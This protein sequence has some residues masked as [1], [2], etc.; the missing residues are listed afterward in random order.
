MQRGPLR[1]VTCVDIGAGLDQELCHHFIG[2]E[3]AHSLSGSLTRSVQE[4]IAK[5]KKTG[6]ARDLLFI[7]TPGSM[8]GIVKA[9]VGV[10]DCIILPVQ[11][12]ILDMVAQEDAADVVGDAGKDDRLLVV[13]N[14]VDGRTGIEDSVQRAAKRFHHTPIK[15]NQRIAWTRALIAGLSGAELD[16]ECARET[17]ALWAS[18][19]KILEEHRNG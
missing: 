11:P 17:A 12:S 10:A 14:R 8:I 7:D 6:F 18:V 2:G 1:V 13:L 9:A 16:K 15:I 5:L 4:A 3:M 19:Q